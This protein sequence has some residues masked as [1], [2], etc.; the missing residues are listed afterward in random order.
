[1]SSGPIVDGGGGNIPAK[2]DGGGCSK[3]VGGGI[4]TFGMGS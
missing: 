3:D 4:M 1:M 2:E